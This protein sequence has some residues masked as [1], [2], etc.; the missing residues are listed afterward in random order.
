MGTRRGVKWNAQFC[1]EGHERAPENL[2]ANKRCKLC[3]RARSRAK[4]IEY[5]KTHPYIWHPDRIRWKAHY[6]PK[7]RFGDS[8][9]NAKQR[10]RE[11]TIPFDLFC[12]LIDTPCRYCGNPTQKTKSGLDRIDNERGYTPDNV[13]PCC[14]RCNWMKNTM[15]VKEFYSHIHLIAEMET[16]YFPKNS[17]YSD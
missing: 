10:N 5:R 8:K 13:C 9:R 11:W 12:T 6:G 1:I 14:T 16:H 17:A 2:Y 15:S 7:Q 4:K 3:A